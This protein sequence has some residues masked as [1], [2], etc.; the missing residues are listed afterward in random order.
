MF[1]FI[2][3]EIRKKYF[4]EMTQKLAI[5]RLHLFIDYFLSLSIKFLLLG[6]DWPHRCCFL[7]R[8]VWNVSVQ[9]VEI[10]RGN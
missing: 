1:W 2:K 7:L 8:N 10:L 3:D 6:S 4:H 9:A 5:M